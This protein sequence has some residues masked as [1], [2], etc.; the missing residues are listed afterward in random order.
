MKNIT[1]EMVVSAWDHM[2]RYY[3]TKIVSKEDQELMQMIGRSLDIMGIMDKERFLET[4]TTTVGDVI[5]I[6]FEIG[7]GTDK[8]PLHTQLYICGHE[9]QHY[10]QYRDGRMQFMLEYLSDSTYRAKYEAQAMHTSME[11]RWWH[12]Q[13]LPNIPSYAMKLHNYNC[14]QIDIDVTEKSLKIT[15]KV[16]KQGGVTTEAGKT[17]IH[18]LEHISLTG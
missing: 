14:P 7:V 3:N 5:Y 12:K 15:S 4:Y 17:L 1:P 13:S 6:P 9:H 11:I 10:V 16:V 2:R 8:H 18:Y